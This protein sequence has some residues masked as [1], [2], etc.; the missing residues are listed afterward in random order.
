M[1]VIH[2]QWFVALQIVA[3]H[4]PRTAL[5]ILT[6]SPTSYTF[7]M[8]VCVYVSKRACTIGM[9]HVLQLLYVPPYACIYA[10]GSIYYAVTHVVHVHDVCMCVCIEAC[11]YHRYV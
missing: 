9:Y 8:H 5:N 10:W 1:M 11:L 2:I 3:A 7:M 6:Q 4:R